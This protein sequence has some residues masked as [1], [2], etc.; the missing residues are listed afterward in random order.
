M[1]LG[2]ELI[3]TD[4]LTVLAHADSAGAGVDERFVDTPLRDGSGVYYLRV[5]GGNND[6]VQLYDLTLTLVGAGGTPEAA[7]D[8]ATTLEEVAVTTNVLANDTGLS[9]T[10]ITL[11]ITSPPSRGEAVTAALPSMKGAGKVQM[12]P[13]VPAA[14]KSLVQHI[15]VPSANRV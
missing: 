3:A 4:G 6:E 1:D 9:D 13:L 5:F 7:D 10:P 12:P 14:V 8:T 2:V 11:T 15:W